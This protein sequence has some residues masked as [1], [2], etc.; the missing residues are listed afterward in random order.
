MKTLEIRT[1]VI[2]LIFQLVF[3]TISDDIIAWIS[4]KKDEKRVQ[5]LL[6]ES[7]AS[8]RWFLSGSV[9]FS[10]WY[11]WRRYLGAIDSIIHVSV[12]ACILRAAFPANAGSKQAWVIKC[13][14]IKSASYSR[15][16]K[17]GFSGYIEP[18]KDRM[19]ICICPIFVNSHLDDI[20][21]PAQSIVDWI[22]AVGNPLVLAI[23]PR[24][25][26]TWSVCC[27][28]RQQIEMVIKLQRHKPQMRSRKLTFD[29]ASFLCRARMCAISWA[30]MKAIWDLIPG[31]I[32]S[33][34]AS[35]LRRPGKSN[36][37]KK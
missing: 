32:W 7:S 1:I 5:N 16:L 3:K 30:T 18:L 14:P 37:G 11:C 25:L 29:I 36:K 21:S 6:T 26:F 20:Y 13:T 2:F 17:I 19:R 8:A 22:I 12:K 10:T 31:V 33:P 34:P 9:L 28:I 24:S 23:K 35:C 27:I 4:G 15:S